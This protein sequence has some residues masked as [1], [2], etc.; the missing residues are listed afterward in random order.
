MPQF[1][2]YTTFVF[3]AVTS[4]VPAIALILRLTVHNLDN[5]LRKTV[6]VALCWC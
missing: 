2:G 3:L 6:K 5:P 1:Y 4:F